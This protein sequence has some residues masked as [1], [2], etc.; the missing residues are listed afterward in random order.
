ME[1]LANQPDAERVD[2]VARTLL[3]DADPLVRSRAAGMVAFRARPGTIE[4]LLRLADDPVPHVRMVLGRYLGG[5]RDRA[6]EPTLRGLLADANEQV[7]KFA[8]RSLARLN[9][10]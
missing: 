5:L 8:A 10:Q 1:G 7:R 2:A 3:A 4:A 6:A 9:R